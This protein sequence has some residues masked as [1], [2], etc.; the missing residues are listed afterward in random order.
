MSNIEVL[1]SQL[2]QV[3]ASVVWTHKIQEKQA[4]IYLRK[5]K[6]LEFIRITLSAITS[7]GIFAVI[8]VDNKWLKIITAIISGVS[9]F[10]TTYYKSYD[11]K[12]LQK[13]HKKSAVELLE[14]REDLVS[15]L[16]DIKV[17]KYNEDKLAEKRDE[18]IKRKIKIAKCTLDPVE[19]AVK[20]ASDNL[21]KRQDN[22]YSDDEI[23]SYLPRLARKSK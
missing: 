22:T 13:Q 4:D 12:S 20:E 16:C 15:V 10:I 11:L 6:F 18:I 5:Y 9:L 1:E 17:D 3:F 19:K 7:S 23:D 21:K 14:L 2:R 8:F